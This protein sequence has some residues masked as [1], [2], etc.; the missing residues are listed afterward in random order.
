MNILERRGP[1]LPATVCGADVHG[2]LMR[3]PC[4][5]SAARPSPSPSPRPRRQPV[6]GSRCWAARRTRTGRR[7][8]AGWSAA[9]CGECRGLHATNRGQQGWN[10]RGISAACEGRFINIGVASRCVPERP[11][12]GG[13]SASRPLGE[14]GDKVR[15]PLRP[16]MFL[17]AV[18]TEMYLGISSVL[19]DKIW[20]ATVIVCCD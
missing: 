10:G 16:F 12:Q 2:A 6:P 15:R 11:H 4:V 1:A 20:G 3:W 17:S 19:I 14:H 8:S 13:L 7:S 5:S 18:V 9:R